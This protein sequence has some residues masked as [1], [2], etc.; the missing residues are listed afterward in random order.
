MKCW[1][2]PTICILDGE[3]RLTVPQP[4]TVRHS[5]AAEGLA[6]SS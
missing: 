2:A 6:K 5:Q 3:F 1:F 4:V